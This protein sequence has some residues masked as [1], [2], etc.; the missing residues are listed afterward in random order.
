MNENAMRLHNNL[1]E[2]KA[3]IQEL[4]RWLIEL[5]GDVTQFRP[6]EIVPAVDRL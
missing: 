1:A 6:R 2:I 5:M 4:L 3:V